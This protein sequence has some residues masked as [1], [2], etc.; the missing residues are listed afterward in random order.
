[1]KL[2]RFAALLLAVLMICTVFVSCSARKSLTAEEFT[3]A[4]E[5]AGYPPE[6]ISEYFAGMAAAA[7]TYS[8]GNVSI[9]YF[10][11]LD[12]ASA[13]S[14]YAAYLSSLPETKSK[15]QVDTTEYNRLLASDDDVLYFLW[16][17]GTKIVIITGTETDALNGLIKNLGI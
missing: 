11:Y 5:E 16:R 8:D 1:M 7:L 12:D 17:N 13:R 6:D 2:R 15:S 10:D 9:G 4:C 3:A 14:D